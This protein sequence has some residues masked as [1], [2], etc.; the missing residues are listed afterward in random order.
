MSEQQHGIQMAGELLMV[1]PGD[2]DHVVVIEAGELGVASVG[3]ADHVMGIE[4]GDLGMVR[5]GDSDH[6]MMREEARPVVEKTGA[7]IF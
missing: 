2:A 7:L 5:P 1:G 6:A 3:D 4:V